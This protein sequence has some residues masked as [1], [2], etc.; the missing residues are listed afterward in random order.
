MKK[1]LLIGINYKGT[2]SELSGCI[3]DVNNMRQYLI[4]QYKVLP[5]NIKVL[6]DEAPIDQKPTYDIILKNFDWLITGVKSGD[7]LFL[8]YSGH[9]SYLKDR[10]KDEEDGRDECICP[11][12]YDKKGFIIDDIINSRL[13]QKI[14]E[15]VNMTSIFDCCH[16][17]TIMDLKYGLDASKKYAITENKRINNNIKANVLMLGGCLDSQT[18]AD[19]MEINSITKK[20]QN[21]GALTWGF[22]E[23]MKKYNNTVEINKFI[24]ELNLLLKNKKYTQIPQLSFS[25]KPILSNNFKLL[26]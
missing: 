1:A 6:T 19:T 21:Q 17:G 18:S 5:Q 12:D 8:H 23:I 24:Q 16:S 4:N 25:K 10:S 2:T 26:R 22:F 3:N 13:L 20:Q 7:S 15:N 9:G 11:L 14:P